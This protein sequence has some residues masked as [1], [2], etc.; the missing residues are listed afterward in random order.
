MKLIFVQM[1]IQMKEYKLYHLMVL[2]LQMLILVN[3]YLFFKLFIKD[4]RSEICICR[5]QIWN[6]VNLE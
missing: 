2:I 1:V 4:G 6:L 3:F 5:W